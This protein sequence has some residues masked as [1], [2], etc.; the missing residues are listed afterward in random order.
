M[1]CKIPRR[2]SNKGFLLFNT[3]VHRHTQIQMCS[4]LSQTSAETTETHAAFCTSHIIGCY[5]TLT[6]NFYFKLSEQIITWQTDLISEDSADP[7]KD[8][9]KC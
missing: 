1:V 5:R 2:G 8:T 7:P 9:Q 3:Y 4:S 6:F